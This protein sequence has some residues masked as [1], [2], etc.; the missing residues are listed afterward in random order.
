MEV[1]WHGNAGC[2]D[3]TFSWLAAA[4]RASAD[5]G[6]GEPQRESASLFPLEALGWEDYGRKRKGLRTEERKTEMLY[7]F[8]TPSFSPLMTHI[9]FLDNSF[10]FFPPLPQAGHSVI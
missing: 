10:F 3:L 5:L 1:V 8:Q 4:L 9:C 2:S 6:G 7:S